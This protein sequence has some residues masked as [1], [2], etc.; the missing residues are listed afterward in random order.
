VRERKA[1]RVVVV[2]HRDPLGGAWVDVGV[3]RDF[4][5][6]LEI[7]ETYT[8]VRARRDKVAPTRGIGAPEMHHRLRCPHGEH[9]HAAVP[10]G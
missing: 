7:D 3:R 6:R 9:P 2:G 10:G 5:P 4:L 8:P 1:A